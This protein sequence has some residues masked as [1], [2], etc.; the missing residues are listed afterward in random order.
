MRK[1]LSLPR[2]R[3]GLIIVLAVLLIVGLTAYGVRGW[4]N[5]NLGAVSSSQEVVYFP[6]ASGSSLHDISLDLKRANLI[7]STTAFEAYVRGRQLYAKMKAGTYALSPSMS[8]PQIVDKIVEGKVSTTNITILPG[9]TIKQIKQTFKQAGYG[10]A[11]IDVALNPSTYPDEAVLAGLPAGASLEGFLYPD[12]FQRDNTTPAET[13]V[14]E[15]LEEMQSHLTPDIVSGFSSQG[16]NVF[17][18]VTLASVVYQEADSP[19]SQ[20]TVAQVF[21]SRLKQGMM[22][23]SDVTAF[24]AS[25]QAGRGNDVTYD[26]AYNTRLHGGLP[27]GPIGNMTDAALKAVAH[28][29]NSDY[30]FFVAGDDGTLH[31]THTQAEHDQAVKQYCHKLCSQ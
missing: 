5:R 14:R 2:R 29:A 31:F 10:D 19:A 23:G 28:P 30:L 16:L 26:S 22:L 4:Y 25:Q 15:S 11:E 12:T 24:Y 27:P 18:G 6:V 17:Q 9:K 20:P 8:T 3:W 13:I 1:R 7:R 21:L